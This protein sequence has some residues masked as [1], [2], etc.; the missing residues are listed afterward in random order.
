VIE[1]TSKSKALIH[2]I[3]Y[4]LVA[5]IVG[6]GNQRSTDEKNLPAAVSAQQRINYLENTAIDE[7]SGLT[8]SNKNN[9]VLWVHNDSGD[10]AR[11]FAVGTQGQHLGVVNIESVSANDW[12]DIASFSKDGKDYL[13]IADVG[14]NSASR[15]QISFHIIEEPDVST[16]SQPFSLSVEAAWSINSTFPDG[17]RDCEGVAVDP[18][19]E[20]II[21][22]TKRDMPPRLYS[23]PISPATGIVSASYLGEVTSIPAPSKEDLQLRHGKNRSRPTGLDISPNGKVIGVL[24]YKDS[25]LF[26]KS[27]GDSWVETLNQPPQALKIAPLKQAEAGGFGLSGDSWFV[28]SERLPA[29]LVETKL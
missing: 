19:S 22:L 28:G 20:E 11:L 10:H 26:T 29:V 14:D 6:C 18:L 27:D 13:L 23:L 24:T 21:L 16:L 5:V 8:R 4:L 12:E 1:Q 17:A 9:N 25:Y 2:T 15:S 3:G 7:A